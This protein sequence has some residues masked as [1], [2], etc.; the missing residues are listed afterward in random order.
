MLLGGL[1][2]SDALSAGQVYDVPLEQAYSELSSM[3]LPDPLISPVSRGDAASVAV[4]RSPR[5]IDWHFQIAGQDVAV[6]TA[7][8]SSEGADRTRVRIAYTPAEP[9]SPELG[10]LTSTALV[11]DL[12]RIAMTEQVSAELENRPVDRDKIVDA[13][14]RHAAAHPDQIREFSRGAGEMVAGLHGQ[15]H[16]N[17]KDLPIAAE[18]LEAPVPLGLDHSAMNAA[19]RPSVELPSSQ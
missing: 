14:A 10:Q 18:S 16:E 9:P 7:T 5:S 2:A 11:R 8:L 12:A 3:P 4:R 19:T 17:S 6:F 15:I 1:Y 13:L